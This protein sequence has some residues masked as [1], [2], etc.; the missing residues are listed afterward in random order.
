MAITVKD[1]YLFFSSRNKNLFVRSCYEY[2]SVFV[3][4]A[5][6]KS[7]KNRDSEILDSLYS[8]DKITGQVKAFKPY[9]ISLDEYE[10][11]KKIG[12]YKM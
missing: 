5:I 11:G 3:F 7:I 4:D 6:P 12:N 9:D 2:A 8:V 1:A 10:N